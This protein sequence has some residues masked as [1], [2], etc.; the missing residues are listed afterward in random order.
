MSTIAQTNATTDDTQIRQLVS[1]LQDGWTKKDGNLFASPFAET[2][3]Y[4]V[5][6]G[7][8]LKGRKEIASSHQMIFNTFYKETNITT[9]VKTIRYLRPDIALVHVSGTM[10]G[11]SNGQP[12]DTKALISLV[13]EKT[14]SGW[15]IV[16]FQNTGVQP[17]PGR[18]SNN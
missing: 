5:I 9:T 3:D 7:M 17:V 10:T 8:Q 14:A 16:A 4:V 6:N 15:Q 2:A 18:P 13:V 11:T 1:S 12:V